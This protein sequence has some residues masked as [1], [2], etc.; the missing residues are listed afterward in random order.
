MAGV[1]GSGGMFSALA[2]QQYAAMARM[3]RQTLR[4]SLRT[5]RGG[6][7]LGSRIFVSVFFSALGLLAGF[8]LGF[9]AYSMATK[10]SLHMLVLI[11]WPVMVAWQVLPVMMSSYQERFDWG[12]MLRFPIGFGSYVLLTLVF[13]LFD[14][15]TLMGGIMLIG[16]WTGLGL[17]VPNLIL[18]TTLV[19]GIFALFNIL[20]T[21]M[22]FAWIDRWLAQRRTREILGMVFLFLMLGVQ[23]LNP[24]LRHY[25]GHH[26]LPVNART[27]HMIDVVQSVFPPGL[28]AD[29]M[30]QS[31]ARHNAAALLPFGSLALY[32]LAAGSLLCLRLRAEY[33]GE[34]LG[35]APARVKV[36]ERKSTAE[37]AAFFR[38]SGPI[39]AVIEK[40]LRM[41]FR[42]GILLYGLAVPL[43]LILV[44]SMNGG[45]PGF[46]SEF[47][48]PLGAIYAFLGFTRMVYNTL[49]GE[50]AGIRLYFLSPTSFRKVLL[51][52]NLFYGG[53]FCAEFALVFLLVIIRTGMPHW[54]ILT[55]T[56]GWLIFVLPAQLSAGNILS[57]T[58]PYRMT[59]T[60]MSREQGAV[61]NGLVSMLIQLI[62]AGVGALVYLPLARNGHAILA[63]PVF[64]L[65]A[66]GSIFFWQRILSNADVLA[67]TR[68]ENLI[69]SIAKA[70]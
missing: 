29:A 2:R 33:R 59:L 40:E 24:A 39:G 28:A 68:R 67:G 20:L 46:S 35:E 62:F 17:A 21:R 25:G 23:F 30:T 58:M 4:H 63:G 52:K 26:G 47:A 19:L 53:L 44:F 45:N 49:G 42:S 7:E 51:A 56:F 5:S 38:D 61:G 12:G 3:R 22:I 54:P 55:A 1:V 60:R 13:G 34:N 8:G 32:M 9:A 69:E 50:G 70:G 57:L 27:L 65:L 16:I 15:S 14:V 36:A 10:H 66:I 37:R 6:F 64:L 41:F 31:D 18:W 43:V 11:L 48:L